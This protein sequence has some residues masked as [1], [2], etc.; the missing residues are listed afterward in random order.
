MTLHRRTYR[1]A[2]MAGLLTLSIL[3]ACAPLPAGGPSSPVA[4]PALADA[5]SA[6]PVLEIPMPTHPPETPV[7]STIRTPQPSDRERAKAHLAAE[8][9]ISPDA[10]TV[11]SAEPVNWPDASLGC[12][13]PGQMY[14]QVITSGY[15]IVLEVDGKTYEYHSGG[16]RIVR[17]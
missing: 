16:G 9:G 13:K 5:A 15:R 17:C 10:V 7:P 1:L 14:A 8:L 12:A 2:W 6:T 4:T 11:V 3:A